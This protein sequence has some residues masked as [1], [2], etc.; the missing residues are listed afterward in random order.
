[1]RVFI[2]LYN[3]HLFVLVAVPLF[4]TPVRGNVQAHSSFVD[5]TGLSDMGKPGQS[6]QTDQWLTR[7]QLFDLSKGSFTGNPFSVVAGDS[8]SDVPS[9]DSDDDDDDDAPV[10]PDVECYYDNH[11]FPDLEQRYVQIS[12]PYFSVSLILI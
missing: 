2:A 9:A 7:S 5:V 10:L 4:S 1:M 6:S 8:G 12:L 11:H 3:V